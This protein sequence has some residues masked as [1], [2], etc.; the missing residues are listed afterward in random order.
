MAALTQCYQQ[1]AP[2]VKLGRGVRLYG[3]ANLYGCEIGED[4]KIGTFVEIQKGAKIGNRCKISSHTFICEGVILE[5]EVFVGHNVTFIND[6]YPRATNG[7]GQLQN[8]ADWQCIRTY[9]KR[10]ASIGSGA[11]LLCGITV[12]ERAMVGA[13]SVVTKDVPPLAVVAGNPA[14]VIKLLP[15]E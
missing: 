14:R 8:E 2:D 7:N 5:D 15:R 10:G 12:G 4:V 6:R 13:G 3:F 1:I 9:V 11:I